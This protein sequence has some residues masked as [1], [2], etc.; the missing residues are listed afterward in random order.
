MIEF[1][2]IIP[3]LQSAITISGDGGF[4]L[5]LEASDDQSDAVPALMALRGKVLRV[6]IEPE[7][8][9]N[10]GGKWTGTKRASSS[11]ATSA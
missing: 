11:K 7:Q 9:R 10:V 4:R 3:S 1:E 6:R 2:A 5:R 8:P